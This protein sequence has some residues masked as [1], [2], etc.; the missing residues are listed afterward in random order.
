MDMVNE[1]VIEADPQRIFE[2][3]GA[4]EQWPQI[5]PHY[6][7]VRIMQ[8]DGDRRVVEMAA[9][10]TIDPLHLAIPVRWQA[11]QINDAQ[12]PQIFFRHLRG[13]TA[14]MQVFWRFT[15]LSNGK[16]RVRIDHTLRSPLA[17]FIGKYF[18]DPI[19][20]RTLQC[21]KEVCESPLGSART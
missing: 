14:G 5:L 12:R 10:R 9:R 3:A 13:W 4:T 11:E 17:G 7:Y 15:P 2:L 8:R 19:A 16:T 20:T 6:R 21:M 18:I 1:I